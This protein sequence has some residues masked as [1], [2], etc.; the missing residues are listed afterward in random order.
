MGGWDIEPSVSELS[1]IHLVSQLRVQA[2]PQDAGPILLTVPGVGNAGLLSIA[3][4]RARIF[5]NHA[6][7]WRI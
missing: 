6:F 7:L 2:S 3:P 1:L 5:C 4:N